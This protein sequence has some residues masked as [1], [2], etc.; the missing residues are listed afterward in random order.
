MAGLGRRTHYRK[1]VT[2]S[3]L[4]DMPE[5]DV[6]ESI[7][8][9]ISTR[10]SNQF[11][12]QFPHSN[13]SQLAILPTKFR[14]LVWLKRN[15]YVIVQKASSSSNGADDFNSSCVKYV[16]PSTTPS[17]SSS[18]QTQQPSAVAP[19]HETG[20][21]RCVVSHILY[22]EQIK[23]LRAKGLWPVDDPKFDLAPGGGHSQQQSSPCTIEA[24][25]DGIVYEQGYDGASSNTGYDEDEYDDDKDLFVNTNRLSR[26]TIQD[27]S[28]SSEESDD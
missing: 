18:S 16:E 7:A 10:G 26:I 17:S 4:H 15:D 24:S 6:D 9:V 13:D 19:T 25:D 27:D 8:V 22:S 21:I 1:H 14:K 11:D 2:D 12:V 3:V 20:S 28:S 5:P 23:H